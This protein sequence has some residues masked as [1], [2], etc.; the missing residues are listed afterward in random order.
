MSFLNFR[1]LHLFRRIRGK[2][3]GYLLLVAGYWILVTAFSSLLSAFYSMRHELCVQSLIFN[4]SSLIFHLVSLHSVFRSRLADFQ[5]FLFRSVGQQSFRGI[6]NKGKP[7]DNEP[8]Q[9]AAGKRFPIDEYSQK[10]LYGRGYV[11]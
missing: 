9:T 10:K 6:N 7:D 11:L 8:Y 1:I 3:T 4:L 2:D 5:N